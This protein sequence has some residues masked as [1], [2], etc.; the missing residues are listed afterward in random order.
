MGLDGIAF[1]GS[2]KD[3]P[4]IMK[5][6]PDSDDEDMQVRHW[7][8]LFVFFLFFFWGAGLVFYFFLLFLCCCC[9]FFCFFFCFFVFFLFF[10]LLVFGK[11]R[12]VEGSENC[13]F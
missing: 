3:D 4:Y 12:P 7:F 5:N 1:Y 10:F 6:I 2:N 11:I 8:C 13:I 9:C